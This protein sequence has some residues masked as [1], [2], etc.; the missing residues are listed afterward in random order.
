M[1]ELAIFTLM[2]QRHGI[3]NNKSPIRVPAFDFSI[4][5]H[6]PSTC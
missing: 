5:V 6:T 2:Q 1:E 3:A 4:L